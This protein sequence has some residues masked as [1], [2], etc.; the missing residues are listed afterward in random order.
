MCLGSPGQRECTPVLRALHGEA[1]EHSS[2]KTEPFISTSSI[3][4]A[5]V[6]HN[7]KH[8]NTVKH[9][10]PWYVVA[11]KRFDG[12]DT[13]MLLTGPKDFRPLHLVYPH[14]VDKLEQ[15]HIL[16]SLTI[17]SKMP[18]LKA[19]SEHLA[20]TIHSSTISFAVAAELP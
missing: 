4:S 8:F 3:C 20:E 19:M 2:L 10:S 1:P 18:G 9:E 12:R 7:N 14:I 11:Q 6:S 16:S 5:E 17:T 15:F 13:V